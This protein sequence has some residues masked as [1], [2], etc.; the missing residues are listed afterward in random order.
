MDN[1]PEVLIT[2]TPSRKRFLAVV[3]VVVILG[4]L[5]FYASRP[6]F[7]SYY[8]KKGIA[9]FPSSVVGN[10]ERADSYLRK[11][12][13]WDNSNPLTHYYL[14]RVAFG[15]GTPMVG[16]T[17]WAEADWL[18]VIEH[19]EKALTLGL[20][21]KDAQRAELALSDIGRAYRK[22]GDYEKGD[23]ILRQHIERY[24]ARSFVSRYL[25]ASDDFAINNSPNEAL[26]ILGPAL[27]VEDKIDLRMFR[28]YTLLARLYT[29]AG[30]FDKGVE[31]AALA[32]SSAPEGEKA[33]P[34]LQIAHILLAH[35]QARKGNIT[36]AESEIH[37]A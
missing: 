35:D 31:Y 8:L 5:G 28:V 36:Q 20:E 37:K 9:E 30:E 23:A 4:G 1:T 32:I 2:E 3:L 13:W 24:P 19:Y 27:E 6:L 17:A 12:L 33:H 14:A 22:L 25:V 18:R 26:E 7:A 29:Y 10:L 15:H 21:N 11:S 16:Y 34:D